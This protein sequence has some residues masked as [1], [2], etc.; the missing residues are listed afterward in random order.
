MSNFSKHSGM[1]AQLSAMLSAGLS[2]VPFIGSDISGFV[3]IW[4]APSKE[5]WIRWTQLGALSG[6]MHTQTH[7]LS[8]LIDHKSHIHDW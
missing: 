8:I 2:G 6:I 1:P 5:L 7:G 4:N 3:W